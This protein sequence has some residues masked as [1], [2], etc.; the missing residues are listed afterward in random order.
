MT[1]NDSYKVSKI[2]KNKIIVTSGNLNDP[3]FGEFTWKRI[4]KKWQIV[5]FKTVNNPVYSKLE[6]K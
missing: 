3:M 1:P 5:E 6:I 4:D 2:N